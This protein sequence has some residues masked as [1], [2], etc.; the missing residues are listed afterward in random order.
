MAGIE[1]PLFGC[2]MSHGAELNE[3]VLTREVTGY[4]ASV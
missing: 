1:V 2:G 3:A 4:H